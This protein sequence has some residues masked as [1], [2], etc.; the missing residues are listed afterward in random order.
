MIRLRQRWRAALQAGSLLLLL[1]FLPTTLYIGHWGEFSDYTFGRSGNERPADPDHASHE[2]HC[3]GISSWSEQPQPGGVRIF[4][5]V[6]ELP[7]P[8]FIDRVVEGDVSIFSQFFL[9]PPTEPPR[10]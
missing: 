4:P 8:S 7:Q 10:V 6:V 3:H 9:T 2:V 1:A 5:T